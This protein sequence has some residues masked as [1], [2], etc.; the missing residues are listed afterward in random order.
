MINPAIREALKVKKELFAGFALLVYDVT[1]A[2]YKLASF[3]D[4][5]VKLAEQMRLIGLKT[6]TVK[7]YVSDEA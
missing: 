5:C 4:I 7:D 1:E 6:E 3:R 2:E